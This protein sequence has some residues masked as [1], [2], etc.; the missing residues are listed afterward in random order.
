MKSIN[1]EF[2]RS[3]GEA[4][5]GHPAPDHVPSAALMTRGSRLNIVA[6]EAALVLVQREFPRI[7]ASL[8]A[9][10]DPLTDE[11]VANM[12]D[13][14]RRIDNCL[15]K[16]IDLFRVGKSRLLLELNRI[17]LCGEDSR[18]QDYSARQ[19]KFTEQHF[20]EADGGGVG[21]LMDWLDLHQHVT[22]W[23]RAAGV[24]TRVLSQPQLY[25]EG[26]H[27]TGA[28]LM[29]YLLAREG[30]PPFVLTVE[31]ARQFFEPATLIKKR[32]KQG[33]DNLLRLPKMTKR[34]AQL[35]EVQADTGYLLKN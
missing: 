16:G 23:K 10:R 33:L 32:K 15:M 14:Y 20:Y 26:N 12:V 34:L 3:T 31:N 35:L 8:T 21:A 24:F 25:V 17:V 11:V 5:A 22:A 30:L 19:L 18:P 27:R 6:I 2:N 7:N 28:L 13:G 9:R 4:M 29:G 1:R